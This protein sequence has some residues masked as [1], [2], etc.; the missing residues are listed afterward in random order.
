MEDIVHVFA[1]LIIC[2]VVSTSLSYMVLQNVFHP[3]QLSQC[4]ANLFVTSW[5]F[6]V[7]YLKLE[8]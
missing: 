2:S 7:A 4:D 8:C 3:L 5:Q 1:D 6:R